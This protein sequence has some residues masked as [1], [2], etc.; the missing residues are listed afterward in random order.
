MLT[1]DTIVLGSDCR[2]I[3]TPVSPRK[4]YLTCQVIREKM[5]ASDDRCLAS[6]ATWA[7]EPSAGRLE[8][9]GDSGCTGGSCFTVKGVEANRAR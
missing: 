8:P 6:S 4:N 3:L 1:I 2:T 5:S 7:P 9:K